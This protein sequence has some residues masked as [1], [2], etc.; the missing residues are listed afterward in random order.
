MV[1]S[2]PSCLPPAGWTVATDTTSA[3]LWRRRRC[4][5]WSFVRWGLRPATKY[6]HVCHLAAP[7][8]QAPLHCTHQTVRIRARMRLLQP[9]EQLATRRCGIGVEPRTQLIRHRRKRV[10]AASAA[11][12]FWLRLRCRSN[13]TV[14][15][16]RAQA[17]D[18]CVDRHCPLHGRCGDAR[19]VRRVGERDQRL[20]GAADLC[21]QPDRIEIGT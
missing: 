20:L 12:C 18:E 10:R 17:R 4:A 5:R 7:D 3:A 13:F 21:Q 1:A 6:E 14:S 8:L 16:R 19:R 2:T 15:P 9:F 11:L